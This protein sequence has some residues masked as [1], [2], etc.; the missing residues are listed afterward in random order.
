MDLLHEGG[1]A[2]MHEFISETAAYGD[3]VSGPRVINEETR[4][5]MRAVLKDIQN[6]TFAH[7]WILENQ[8]GK[9]RYDQMMEADLTHNI[10]KVGQRLRDRMTW[11]QPGANNA[12]E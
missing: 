3:M 11:L 12:G 2:K 4:D 8:A 6:G 5:R 1:I 10:E 9:A 7:N